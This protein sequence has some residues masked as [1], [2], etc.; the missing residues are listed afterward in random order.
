MDR[1][2]F[3]RYY[4]ASSFGRQCNNSPKQFAALCYYSGAISRTEEK[5]H[6]PDKPSVDLEK[7]TPAIVSVWNAIGAEIEQNMQGMQRLTNFLC[8]ECCLDMDNL[9]TFGGAEGKQAERIISKAMQRF[10]V[11]PILSFLARNIL[12]R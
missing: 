1:D 3:W 6:K 11:D 2:T 10:G 8:I 5:S 9:A 7:V 4:N 12:L